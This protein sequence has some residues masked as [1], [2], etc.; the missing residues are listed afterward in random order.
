MKTSNIQKYT[1]YGFISIVVIIILILI[2]CLLQKDVLINPE[3]YDLKKDGICIIKNVF[4][5]KD[6]AEMVSKSDQDDYKGLKTQI[7]NNENLK[8]T[9]A[10]YS[11]P[12]YE[13]HD[14]IFI[15]K[16]S[17]I[18]TCHRDA[19]GDMFNDIQH[20]SYTMLIYLQDMEKCLGVIPTSHI[21]PG[22]YG[23]NI[24]NQLRNVLCKKGDILLFDANL[25]HT[26]ALNTS[27]NNLR[28]Q[29]KY[30]H[31]DDISKLDFYTDYHKILKT[32]NTK[33]VMYQTL[34][35][36]VSCMFPFV[37]DLTQNEVKQNKDVKNNDDLPLHQQAFNWAVYGNKN[38]YNLPNAY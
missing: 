27:P 15:I 36:N 12:D 21:E 34:V 2:Y 30:S 28:V 20:P 25:I 16:K 35:K 3:N 13:F 6:L 5:E 26:G 9:L 23:I 32:E 10:Q 29:M 38:Y 18:S 17:S 11:G 22:S 8:K 37:S 4:S 14:Y 7:V 1:L 33:P 19:N 31:S 24:Q